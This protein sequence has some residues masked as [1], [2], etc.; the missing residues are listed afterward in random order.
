MNDIIDA[1]TKRRSIRRYRPEQI[2]G[3]ELNAVLTAGVYAP[4]GM[5][6]Q[7]PMI[8]AVQDKAVRDELS[9][10][11]AEIM[12]TSSDPFY[13]APTVIV[14]FADS[15]KWTY[16]EDGSLVI[17]NMLNAA[18]SLG[19]G[20]CWIHRARETF[21]TPRGKELMAQ[22]GVPEGYRG[23]GNCILGYAACELPTP[24][25]RKQNYII[26]I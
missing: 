6:A 4:T 23:V 13:G 24:S 1:L 16:I 7:S 8:V 20:S 22:W 26:K 18:Y 3:D 9:R 10:I 15:E 2:T 12:D 19:L 25:E 17:G 21:D 5:N 14:V 11:N